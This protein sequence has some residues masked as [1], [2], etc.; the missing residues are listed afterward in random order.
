[1]ENLVT[2]SILLREKSQAEN[3]V[4][5]SCHQGIDRH[6]IPDTQTITHTQS[7]PLQQTLLLCAH[8]HHFFFMDKVLKQLP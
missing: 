2:F 7:D 8:K 3:A 6:P 4:S 5:I 1:M